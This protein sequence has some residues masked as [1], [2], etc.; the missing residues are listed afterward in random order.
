MKQILCAAALLAATSTASLACPAASD[1]GRHF[2]AADYSALQSKR[3][4]LRVRAALE[5][6]DRGFADWLSRQP[7]QPNVVTAQSDTRD[8]AADSGLAMDYSIAVEPVMC[9]PID[10]NGNPLDMGYTIYMPSADV[11][12]MSLTGMTSGTADIP[13][14]DNHW[15]DY[16]TTADAVVAIEGNDLAADESDDMSGTSTSWWIVPPVPYEVRDY[17]TERVNLENADIQSAILQSL[18][19]DADEAAAME[20][21]HNGEVYDPNSGDSL[22]MSIAQQDNSRMEEFVTMANTDPEMQGLVDEMGLQGA[23]ETWLGQQPAA[24]D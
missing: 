23:Y 15:L 7:N 4:D 19:M 18:A 22:D 1:Q 11:A 6:W 9:M 14:G 5:G 2:S 21:E 3:A 13:A 17:D 24:V 10:E 16:G 12:N 8:M 20:R